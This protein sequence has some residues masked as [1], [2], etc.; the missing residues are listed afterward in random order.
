MIHSPIS[1]TS[2]ILKEQA[3]HAEA[4]GEFSHIMMNLGIAGKMIARDLRHAGIIDVLGSTGETNVQG[5]DVQKLD[6]RANEIFIKVFRANE[7]VKTMV[8]EE[9]EQPHVFSDAQHSGKYALYLDPLDGSSNIDV[10]APLGSIFSLHR[11]PAESSGHHEHDLLKAG[12]E[13]VGGGYFL[14]GTSTVFVYTC[15]KGVHQFT[16]EPELGEFFLTA[17]NIRMPSHGKI[18]SVNEGNCQKWSP[19]IRQYVNDIKE[20]D[21]ATNRPYG[22]RYTGCLVADVHRILFK[23][24]VYLYPGEVN[25]PEG[26]L[27]LMYE[28]A[29]LSFV[30]EQAGGIGSTGVE[31]INAIQPKMLHQRVPLVIG[32]RQNVEQVQEYMRT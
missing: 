3:F 30:I 29:P 32:S 24:G 7:I 9:M 13:Q 5:E 23:G 1:L 25:K 22:A 19:G 12:S 27:R 21:T 2:H 15:G 8:S 17:K 4:T 20:T 26:K 28:A 14:Y 6:E 16:L 18:Y 31:P 11:L 10:N